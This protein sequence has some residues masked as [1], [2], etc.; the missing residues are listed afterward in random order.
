[1]YTTQRHKYF[2]DLTR[3][4]QLY[5]EIRIREHSEIYSLVKTDSERCE[6]RK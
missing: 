3:M 1:M 6:L 5:I 2:V 4:E